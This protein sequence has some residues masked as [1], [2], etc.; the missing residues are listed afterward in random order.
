M[1]CVTTR[2][3]GSL[4][5]RYAL[6]ARGVSIPPRSG[7]PMPTLAPSLLLVVAIGGVRPPRRNPLHELAGGA[8][9]D[10]GA[11]GAARGVGALVRA[12]HT[13]DEPGCAL[14]K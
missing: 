12:D 14:S 3:R 10:D 2:A 7:L 6:R 8:E 9:A 13:R 11:V 5:A 4:R 1:C